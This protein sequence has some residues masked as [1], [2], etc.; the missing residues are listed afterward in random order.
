V[1]CESFLLEKYT[2]TSSSA[3]YLFYSLRSRVYFTSLPIDLHI[4]SK[5]YTSDI[6]RVSIFLA[7]LPVLFPTVFLFLFAFSQSHM[8]AISSPV[9]FPGDNVIPDAVMV[10]DQ[11]IVIDAKRADV[12]PWVLQVG[13]GRGGWYMPFV[14][15]NF[16]PKSWHATRSINPEWQKL[17][18]GDRVDDYGFSAED[19]FIVEEI[20]PQQALV[21]KSDRYGAHF[22]WS[23]PL[24]DI[25]YAAA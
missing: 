7:A 6:I 18:P 14:W 25:N 13:K 22:S 11:S 17:K 3:D 23:V 20:Q 8:Q 4:C 24:K 16:L 19:Y 2:A 15:D 10:Y 5:M 9:P 1:R 21:Y 12:W